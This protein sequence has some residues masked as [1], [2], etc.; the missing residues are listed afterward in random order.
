MQ[1]WSRYWYPLGLIHKRDWIP[2][3]IPNGSGIKET[4]YTR[5][6]SHGSCL[7]FASCH[8]YT[9]HKEVLVVRF[10]VKCTNFLTTQLKEDKRI[11]LWDWSNS[12]EQLITDQVGRPLTLDARTPEIWFLL[13][14]LE[15][16]V[17]RQATS[18][19]WPWF[20]HLSEET[21]GSDGFKDIH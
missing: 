15:L 2:S 5:H 19:H 3:V 20:S 10:W 21:A 17:Q 11:Q 14:Y 18:L 12:R 9:T 6:L 13:C 4:M 7:M 1:S 16:R 8:D